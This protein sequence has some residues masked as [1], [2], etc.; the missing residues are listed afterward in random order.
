MI[1]CLRRKDDKA[2]ITQKDLTLYSSMNTRRTVLYCNG[3]V[4]Y[5]DASAHSHLQVELPVPELGQV[6]ALLQRLYNSEYRHMSYGR[7][8]NTAL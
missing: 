2:E 6:T 5:L 3:I 1:T 8:H 7:L 4:S